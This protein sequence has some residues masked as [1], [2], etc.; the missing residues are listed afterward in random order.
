MDAAQ[1]CVYCGSCEINHDNL[2]SYCGAC[3][4]LLEEKNLVSELRFVECS[5][6]R[7]AACG[8]RRQPS[9]ELNR[10]TEV[11]ITKIV[12]RLSLG[13]EIK[14]AGCRMFQLAVRLNF[15]QG[16]SSRRVAAACLYLECRRKRLPKLLI[17]FSDELGERS[18]KT[19]ARVY[20]KLVQRLVGDPD[21]MVK[22]P[23]IDPSLFMERFARKLKLGSLRRTIQDTANRLIRDM[24]RH[25]ICEG[26]RPNGL[27]GAALLIAA[28]H[29]GQRCTA[30]DIADVVRMSEQTLRIRLWELKSTPFAS[31]SREEF[32][33]QLD[34]NVEDV[35]SGQH[36]L[37]PVMRKRQ[38]VEQAALVDA[39]R[40]KQL[41]LQSA[42]QQQASEAE[43]MPP[44]ERLPAKR[45][46]G[47]T[48]ALD[49]RPP[50]ADSD[51]VVHELVAHPHIRDII[52][53]GSSCEGSYSPVSDRSGPP[54]PGGTGAPAGKYTAALP[55]AGDLME[56]AHDIASQNNIDDLFAQGP[57]SPGGELPLTCSESSDGGGGSTR[58][59]GEEA[60]TASSGHDGEIDE[61][62]SDV[63]DEE[64]DVYFLDDEEYQNKS[65]IWHEVNKEYLQE[66]YERG[67]EA[68]RRKQQRAENTASEPTDSQSET[69]S[70]SR[71][72]RRS[73]YPAASSPAHS[74]QMALI[75]KGK[76]NPKRINMEELEDLF[77]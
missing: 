42:S 67:Q 46:R 73:S 4:E 71:G 58:G 21:V 17:D 43:K 77:S 35:M 11:T 56:I 62:L 8:Q 50:I 45:R 5:N 54:T 16:R 30:E 13:D 25:W 36:T 1:R 14:E 48:A 15:T 3:G 22:V 55:S 40:E 63:D 68:R 27:C 2:R 31:M 6:G 24:R 41:A 19:L 74:A 64:L 70:A 59:L 72:S 51:Q 44:P 26:R 53:Q 10:N 33:R 52:E 34:G 39:E 69:G 28:F 75:K 38:R 47:K 9:H 60:A 32:Q 29:H 23:V 61:S 18:V 65:D 12:H 66:W 57:G 20:M 76:I 49:E 37:P 7:V